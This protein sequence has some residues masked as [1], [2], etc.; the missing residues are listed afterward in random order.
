[1]KI[2]WKREQVSFFFKILIMMKI[3]LLI[4]AF[5]L[6]HA[7]TVLSQQVTIRMKNATYDEVLIKMSKE[8]N[9]DLVFD[10]KLF[11]GLKRID[12]DF[13]NT[14][15]RDALNQLFHNT[16]FTYDLS[17]GIIVI[18]KKASSKASVPDKIL[19]Q[20]RITG[21]VTDMVGNPLPSVT[22]AVKNS[23]IASS[24]DSGGQFEIEIP[25]NATSLVFS[26]I[27]YLEKE[28]AIQQQSEINV[29]LEASINNL[30]EVVVVGYGTQN[31]R[32]I[33]GSVSNLKEEEFN[34]GV[35]RNAVDLLRGKIPGLTITSGSG[36][37]SKGETIRL[38][39]TSSLTG[40]SSPF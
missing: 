22:I 37:V 39:G 29:K 31:K 8:V 9:Y 20:R 19:Q 24:T 3:L 2:P 35:N 6:L 34:K 36:D 32:L 38:R 12:I 14:T 5:T 1:M 4:C 28:I 27:G 21:K 25:T 15:I 30:D 18:R 16:P 33:S 17:G 23:Q 13:K 26:L 10:P 40:S 7:S 11:S